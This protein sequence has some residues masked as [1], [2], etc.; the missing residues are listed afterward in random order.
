MKYYLFVFSVIAAAVSFAVTAGVAAILLRV[1][2]AVLMISFGIALLHF[3]RVKIA[4]KPVPA[5]FATS[6]GSKTEKP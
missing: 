2:S 6:F 4:N 1:F 5:T 3:K